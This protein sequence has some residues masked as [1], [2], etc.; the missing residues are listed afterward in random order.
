MTAQVSM[1]SPFSCHKS[2]FLGVP[3]RGI[4]HEAW[5]TVSPPAVRRSTVL[6]GALI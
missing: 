6:M 5:M 3:E 2:P 1:A 4:L